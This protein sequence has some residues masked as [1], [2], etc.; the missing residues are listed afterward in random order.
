MWSDRNIDLVRLG[1]NFG[2]GRMTFKRVPFTSIEA[3]C[4]RVGRVITTDSSKGTRPE[5]VSEAL[6]PLWVDVVSDDGHLSTRC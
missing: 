1:C 6:H 4:R 5:I 3:K 2:L